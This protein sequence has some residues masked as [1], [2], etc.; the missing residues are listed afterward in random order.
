MTTASSP[1]PPGPS[2]APPESGGLGFIRSAVRFA[3]LLACAGLMGLLVYGV[4]ARSPD[5][6]VDDSLA[7]ARAPSA[8]GF[9]LAVLHR[10]DLG[11]QLTP[12][13]GRALADGRV[14]LQELRGQ[15]VVLNFWASWCIPC[16]EEAPLLERTWRNA[17]REGV[18]FVGLDMQDVT[19]DARDFLRHFR[20][21][22]LNVRD[23]SNTVARRYGVT[24]LPETFFI[25]PD[26][27]IVS[28][29]IGVST[30]TDLRD[31]IDATA[32]G[33]P[34]TARRAG[35]QGATK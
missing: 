23:P 5:T 32:T 12:S 25:T 13:A 3:A 30:P 7:N 33:R 14:S 28:H 34:I 22:Y 17:R 20:I 16:R 2:A 10:G 35:A 9:T 19:A 6:T 15:R 21:D 4:A 1:T 26:G 24:G 31:G 29:V 18:L 11:P 8:P 27:R